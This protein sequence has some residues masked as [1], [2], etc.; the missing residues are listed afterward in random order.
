MNTKR[1]EKLNVTCKMLALAAVVMMMSVAFTACS[2]DDDDSKPN[3]DAVE[4]VDLGLPSGTKWATCNVGANKPEQSGNYYAWG[5]IK[6]KKT[7]NWSTYKWMQKGQN[8][9]KFITKYTV[10]DEYYD[11]IWYNSIGT[12]IGDNKNSLEDEDDAA[13]AKLGKPWRTPTP[14]E[15]QELIDNCEWASII[16]NGVKCYQGKSRINQET[17]TLPAAGRRYDDG[18][19]KDNNEALYWSNSIF[20]DESSSAIIFKF[21]TGS[22]P[23]ISYN[24]RQFGLPV[25]PVRK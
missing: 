1:L 21:S 25:R 8:D 3:P 19:Q 24:I 18:L 2:S 17:I 22:L 11:C 13:T 5:E 16:V 10:P 23:T 15:F 9:S 6:T 4:Y 12:F 7:Y 14:E 20:S